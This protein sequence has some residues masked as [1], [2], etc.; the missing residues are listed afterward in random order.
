MTIILI[1][2]YDWVIMYV[3]ICK[4]ITES[5]IHEAVEN[6]AASVEELNRSLGVAGECGTCLS[7]A[8]QIL[9]EGLTQ[10][11]VYR[12]LDPKAIHSVAA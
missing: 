12:R 7:Y 2:I 8:E 3:C 4:G 11:S 6:G 9:E 10:K 5:Q 1:C